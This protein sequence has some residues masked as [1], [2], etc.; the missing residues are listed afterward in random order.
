MITS[1]QSLAVHHEILGVFGGA[2][3]PELLTDCRRYRRR[4]ATERLTRLTSA[5][6]DRSGCVGLLAET[7]R[8]EV[9]LA[10][11]LFE[12]RVHPTVVLADLVATLVAV[13]EMR[14]SEV[15]VAGSARRGVVQADVLFAPATVHA[16]V[17]REEVV[18]FVALVAVR[19]AESGPGCLTRNRAP[20][21]QFRRTCFTGV[22]VRRTED[23]VADIALR[24]MS[25]TN[26]IITVPARVTVTATGWIAT[27]G[28]VCQM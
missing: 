16:V 6:D 4:V 15:L 18:A 24:L 28:T 17:R 1:N 23:V 27:L 2:S 10:G 5:I 25:F 21:T 19:L 3:R 7:A 20:G 12:N 11:G 8:N 14:L 22:R 13:G 26:D 9:R